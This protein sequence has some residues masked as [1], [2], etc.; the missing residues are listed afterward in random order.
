MVPQSNDQE[1]L[2]EEYF[3]HALLESRVVT[4]DLYHVSHN[5][6]KEDIVLFVR[7]S[8]DK[9]FAVLDFFLSPQQKAKVNNKKEK[10]NN[11]S[12]KKKNFPVHI[13]LLLSDK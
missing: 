8:F 11:N 3:V 7:A 13:V 4:C 10:K 6:K 12:S 9:Y 2:N 5:K 1:L